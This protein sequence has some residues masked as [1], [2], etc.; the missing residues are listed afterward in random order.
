MAGKTVTVEDMVSAVRSLMD[1]DNNSAINTDTDILPALNRAQDYASNILARHYE[2]PLLDYTII[3]LVSGKS[4]YE[5]P[6]GSFEERIEKVE[7][8]QGN[9]YYPLTRVS[10]RDIS[11][12]ETDSLS[13][14]PAY[15]TV[16]NDKFRL[17]PGPTGAYS[18]RVWY[19]R[20]PLPLVLP[21]GRITKV[22]TA[23][24][25]IL[26]D[27]L[28]DDLTTETDNLNSY[29]SVIDGQS[30]VV[31]GSLQ[32]KT[33]IDTKII[34]KSIPSRTSVYNQTIGDSI[35]GFLDSDGNPLVV[36][37][38]D[39]ICVVS[40]SCIP[41]FKKPMSNFLVQ[42]AVAELTRKLGGAADMEQRVLKDLEEQ[43]E[44]SWAGRES[45]MRVKMSNNKW[46]KLRRRF[47]R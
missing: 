38:D 16:I 9:L 7:V 24:N 11:E 45:T 5:I 46:S 2:S 43:V 8:K 35:G 28:G 1:E 42:Y 18:L 20:D 4:N 23:G 22:D 29:I 6:E 17:V 19:L 13:N 40:G 37:A 3:P 30:G 25:F 41:F 47:W 26:V 44:R 31:K 36:D 14:I 34:F 39:F 21:Q 33:I 27:S 10:Y 32:I 15:Y 12:Y